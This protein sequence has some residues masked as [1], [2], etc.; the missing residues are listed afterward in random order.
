LTLRRLGKLLAL[1]AHDYAAAH[2]LAD[3]LFGQQNAGRL[4]S[5]GAPAG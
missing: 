5:P 3:F 2:V 1:D 4:P